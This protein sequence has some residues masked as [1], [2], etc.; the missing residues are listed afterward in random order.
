M[1]DNIQIDNGNTFINRDNRKSIEYL[2]KQGIGMNCV[3]NDSMYHLL[4]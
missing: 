3:K 2:N 4:N 1:K